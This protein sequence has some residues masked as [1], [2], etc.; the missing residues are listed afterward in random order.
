[1]PIVL[2][3]VPIHAD[4]LWDNEE[5]VMRIF[6]MCIFN[7]P[8][9]PVPRFPSLFEVTVVLAEYPDIVL[10]IASEKNSVMLP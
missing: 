8:L 2:L 7:S 10:E 6:E 1:M 5:E 9:G 4:N 3:I